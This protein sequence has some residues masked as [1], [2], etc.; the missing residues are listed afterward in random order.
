MLIEESSNIR[1]TAPRGTDHFEI[2]DRH[3]RTQENLFDGSERVGHSQRLN[4]E[5]SE[6]EMKK[7]QKGVSRLDKDPINKAKVVETS[8]NLTN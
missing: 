2:D 6:F 8:L 3:L 1:R 4:E 7:V 5:I